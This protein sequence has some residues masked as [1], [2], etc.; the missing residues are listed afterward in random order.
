MKT[1]RYKER[2]K[3]MKNNSIFQKVEGNFYNK[4]KERSTYK[5]QV[6]T[7]NKFQWEDES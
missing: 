2:D 5:G 6:Q 1:E 3:A 4:T 7:I